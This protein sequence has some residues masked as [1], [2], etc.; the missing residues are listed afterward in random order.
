MTL[1]LE[2]NPPKKMRMTEDTSSMAILEDNEE[3]KDAGHEDIPPVLSLPI[4][5]LWKIF[6]PLNYRECLRMRLIC[7]TF[8]MAIGRE[9]MSMWLRVWGPMDKNFYSPLQGCKLS[10]KAV[11]LDF[12]KRCMSCMSFVFKGHAYT[13]IHRD[14]SSTI[15]LVRS[16]CISHCETQIVH[17]FIFSMK[18]SG[19]RHM[20]PKT[21]DEDN[22]SLL[23]WNVQFPTTHSDNA[24]FQYEDTSGKTY[25]VSRICKKD[26]S[27]IRSYSRESPSLFKGVGFDQ[28]G[29]LEDSCFYRF[30]EDLR[31]PSPYAEVQEGKKRYFFSI[32]KENT[33]ILQFS[34]AARFQPLV[35]C[36]DEEFISVYFIANSFEV[37][38]LVLHAQTGEHSFT[39]IFSSEELYKETPHIKDTT[40]INF[41]RTHTENS[42]D[43]PLGSLTHIAMARNILFLLQRFDN[44]KAMIFALNIGRLKN[45]VWKHLMTLSHFADFDSK[46]GFFC[47]EDGVTIGNIA[48]IF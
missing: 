16:G 36:Q 20:I 30:S 21:L 17:N 33:R 8:A 47:T 19:Y 24:I 22:L 44:D 45:R 11:H 26:S 2:T 14:L 25:S 32:W 38:H 5:I 29:V 13:V 37:R 48:F 3:A 27:L 1:E 15:E 18:L 41:G 40:R 7:R 46:M 43:P 28:H 10:L 12:M 31:I 42:Q 23:C 6:L 9:F 34:T 39:T 35:V 4:E